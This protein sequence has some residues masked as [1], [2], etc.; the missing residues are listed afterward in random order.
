M[1][2]YI[3]IATMLMLSVP[4]LV[5]CGK[6]KVSTKG[7][8]SANATQKIASGEKMTQKSFEKC[9]K[10]EF[11]NLE[12]VFGDGAKKHQQKPDVFGDGDKKHYLC[13]CSGIKRREE[14][15]E[16]QE[17]FFYGLPT[18]RNV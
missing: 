10:S 3:I 7:G 11:N 17:L 12:D 16:I 18:L 14:R 6:E 13:L 5:G 2:K 1:K 15:K 4:T 9:E 8:A